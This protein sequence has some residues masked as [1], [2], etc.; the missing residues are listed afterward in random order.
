ML[1]R[2]VS[3]AP[4]PHE[5]PSQVPAAQHC[6]DKPQAPTAHVSAREWTWAMWPE[7]DDRGEMGTGGLNGRTLEQRVSPGHA[8]LR[9]PRPKEPLTQRPR[10]LKEGGEVR[11][12]MGSRR[13][14]GLGRGGSHRQAVSQGVS[15]ERLSGSAEPPAAEMANSGHIL[16]RAQGGV[17]GWTRCGRLIPRHWPGQPS[18]ERPAVGRAGWGTVRDGAAMLAWG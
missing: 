8:W 13:A 7:E 5:A 18:N 4:T 11:K 3:E 15:L 2:Q 9:N 12:E 16:R 6:K 1:F 17:C 10:V 14:L